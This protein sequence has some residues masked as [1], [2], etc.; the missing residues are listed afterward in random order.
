MTNHV[1][2][3]P[4]SS[5]M[6]LKNSWEFDAV[7]RA[8]RQLKGELVRIYYLHRDCETKIGTVVGKKVAGAVGRA[9][10][11]R[12]LRESFRRIL[13]WMK[14]GVWVVASLRERAL[15]SNAISIYYE[16]AGLFER[17]SFLRDDWS[18]A[19]WRV[20]DLRIYRE[21]SQ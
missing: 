16:M 7:F 12:L 17:L 8:G 2:Q 11:R 15:C 1:V 6:R 5:L 14:G 10:G 9:R 4:F 18:G 21:I 3:F 20:D 19:D 13:P